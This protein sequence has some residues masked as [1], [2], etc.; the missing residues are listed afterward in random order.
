MD[1]LDREEMNIRIEKAKLEL[2]RDVVEQVAVLGNLR[3]K[4]LQ[5]EFN[6]T[7]LKLAVALLINLLVFICM[8][9]VEI[10]GMKM[11]TVS[12]VSFWL[13]MIII[14][15]IFNSYQ[16][17]KWKKGLLIVVQIAVFALIVWT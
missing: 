10:T 16:M 5:L 11:T 1:E 13:G 15:L 4:V 8:G 6:S 3:I 12:I 9:V 17:S 14:F 2:M 7:V